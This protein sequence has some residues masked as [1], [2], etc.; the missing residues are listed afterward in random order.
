[1]RITIKEAIKESRESIKKYRKK[2]EDYRKLNAEI[3]E[4]LYEGV[5]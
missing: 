1:M 2:W 4:R 3:F 5:E